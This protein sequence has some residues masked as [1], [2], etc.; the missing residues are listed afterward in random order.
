M[1]KQRL[2]TSFISENLANYAAKNCDY[3]KQGTIYLPDDLRGLK[4]QR[5]V[6]EFTITEP[7]HIPTGIHFNAV[8]FFICANQMLRLICAW[9]ADH[10][11]LIL[12][13]QAITKANYAEKFKQSYIAKVKQIEFSEVI[14]PDEFY[15][16]LI[17]MKEHDIKQQKFVEADVRFYGNNG[18]KAYGNMLLVM[19]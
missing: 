18:G 7:V 4:Q 6:G 8:E 13:G 14:S 5:F 12:N 15:G 16:E 19:S 10:N 3:L 11:Q 2:E 9:N 1:K 17:I